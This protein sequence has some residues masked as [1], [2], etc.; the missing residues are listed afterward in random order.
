MAQSLQRR[1]RILEAEVPKSVVE[2]RRQKYKLFPQASGSK[3]TI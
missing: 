2:G 1:R 3:K